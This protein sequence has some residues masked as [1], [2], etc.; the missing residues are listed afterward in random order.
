MNSIGL[1]FYTLSAIM[2]TIEAHARSSQSPVQRIAPAHVHVDPASPIVT[3][4]MVESVDTVVS[5]ALAKQGLVFRDG[6][7][8]PLANHTFPR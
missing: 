3:S 1:Y 6:Y 7:M 5:N 2:D 4:L 8:S